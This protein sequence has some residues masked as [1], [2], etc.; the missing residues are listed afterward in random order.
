M[1]HHDQNGTMPISIIEL[2]TGQRT[3]WKA[4]RPPM[5]V[6]EV[7][8]PLITPDGHAYAY[9]FTYVRSQ[10]YLGEGVR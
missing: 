5:A 3:P 4:L 2:Q 10:L 7:S 6:D 8:N 9:N 1:T